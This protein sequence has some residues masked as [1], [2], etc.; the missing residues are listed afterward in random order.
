MDW[1]LYD[2]DLRHERVKS[3]SPSKYYDIFKDFILKTF[4]D[5]F[6][7]KTTYRKLCEGGWFKLSSSLFRL[8][9][10]TSE[11][12]KTATLLWFFPWFLGSFQNLVSS[13]FRIYLMEVPYRRLLFGVLNGRVK[14]AVGCSS[15]FKGILI[16]LIFPSPQI[17]VM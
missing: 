14:T 10:K 4:Q 3:I 2:N 13:C 6:T 17:L 11:P 9:F 12:F 1:F 5:T 8:S 7:S 15:Y 16:L